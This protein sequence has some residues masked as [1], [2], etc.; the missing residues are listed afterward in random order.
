MY[1]HKRLWQDVLKRYHVNQDT[2]FGMNS[3][4]ENPNSDTSMINHPSNGF[5]DAPTLVPI[6]RNNE[7]NGYYTLEDQDLIRLAFESCIRYSESY[8][9]TN[10]IRHVSKET[11]ADSMSFK[12]EETKMVGNIARNDVIQKTHNN[13]LTDNIK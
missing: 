1:A 2:V 8:F 6:I 10:D 13:I 3:E 5:P 4:T 12:S 9:L 7:S 11:T